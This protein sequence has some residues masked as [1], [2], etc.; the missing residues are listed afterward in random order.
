MKIEIGDLFKNLDSKEYEKINVRTIPIG[1][2][3]LKNVKNKVFQKIAI[4]EKLECNR[5]KSA[6]KS[7]RIAWI[8]AILVL[9][10]GTTVFA[11]N[12]PEY[13]KWIFGENAKIA[14]ENIQEIVAT[15]SN[16]DYIFTVESLLSDGNQNYFVISLE[17]KDG[18]EIGDVVLL[19]GIKPAEQDNKDE[20]GNMIGLSTTVMG[21]EKISGLED[22]KNKGYYLFE[23]TTNSSLMGKDVELTL[24]GLRD[25]NSHKVDIFEDK[26]KVSFNIGEYNNN[27]IKTVVVENP[28]V[29]DDRYYITEI[30]LSNLG[31][32]LKGKETKTTEPIPI[33]NIQLKYKDGNIRD[34]AYK[35]SQ[36][37][38][39]DFPDAG[40]IFSRNPDGE[41]FT[42]TITFG[43]LIDIDDIESI[44]VNE[45][46]YSLYQ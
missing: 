30:K 46:E 17:K 20:Q 22:S 16:K 11:L 1:A 45:E 4:D 23:A 44:I 26:L 28:K 27:N 24:K 31:L 7:F 42:N 12:K 5:E 21:T 19:M 39:V 9:A 6:R 29:I 18:K 10:V 3:S 14:E 2:S 38:N 13:F 8:A 40:H 41:E 33:P 15:A 35:T 25:K 34:L 43:E 36:N 37:P 32:N